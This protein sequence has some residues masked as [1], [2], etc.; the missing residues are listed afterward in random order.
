M[1]FMPIWDVLFETFVKNTTAILGR[2]LPQQQNRWT[3]GVSCVIFAFTLVSRKEMNP[4]RAEICWEWLVLY[5]VN[6]EIVGLTK[7]KL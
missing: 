7:N 5:T 4:E 3:K 1:R 6:Q 2:L